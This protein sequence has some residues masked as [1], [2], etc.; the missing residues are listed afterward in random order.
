MTSLGSPFQVLFQP[1]CKEHEEE[2]LK[3]SSISPFSSTRWIHFLT[4]GNQSWQAWRGQ[5]P[6]RACRRCWSI[7]KPM[8]LVSQGPWLR[9]RRTGN[10]ILTKSN[11]RCLK[12][13]MKSPMSYEASEENQKRPVPLKRQE[14]YSKSQMSWDVL[15]DHS[16]QDLFQHEDDEG[17]AALGES[18][19]WCRR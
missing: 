17:T 8:S 4:L 19:R 9:R 1:Q 6:S 10:T 12:T 18:Y 3:N 13:M 5:R 14:D 2:L 7:L 16:S 15:E 11:M